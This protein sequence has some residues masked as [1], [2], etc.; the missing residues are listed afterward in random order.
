MNIIIP[1][2]GKDERFSPYNEIK[3]LIEIKGKP[4]IKHCT[5]SLPFFKERRKIYFIV[6]KE[7]DEQYHLKSRLE[8]LYGKEHDVSIFIQEG[9]RE[10]AASTVLQLKDTINNEEPLVI[11]LADIYF[12]APLAQ[13]IASMKECIGLVPCFKSSNKKY[14]YLKLENP[15][16]LKSK[17]IAVAEKTVIS[18]NASAGLYYFRKGK[19]FVWAAEEMIKKNRRVNNMFYICP[20]YQEF[21]ER[22]DIVKIIPSIFKFGLGSPEEVEEFRR[23]N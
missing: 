17:A 2:A 10:G 14:S 7:H 13:S 4:L 12:E 5:D 11:Y 1:L 22:G 6:L 16:D 18:D 15:V 9:M 19:D 3:P 21:V 8:K 23:G 20:V